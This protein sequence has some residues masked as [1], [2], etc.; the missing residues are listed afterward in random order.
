MISGAPGSGKTTQATALAKQYGLTNVN[1]NVLVKDETR[2]NPAIKRRIEVC[3][4]AGDP[5]PNEI[6]LRI[7][8]DRLK[9]SDCRMNGGVLD[10]FP[11]DEAQINLLK[12]MRVKP[13][14]FFLLDLEP[15][16]SKIRLS[17]RRIDPISGK[18]YALTEAEHRCHN[19]TIA[20]RLEI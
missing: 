2:R 16:D 10:G 17:E 9:C 4:D 7:V 20:N 13:D 5:I 11:E 12:S 18:M 3:R 6:L 15:A 8:E 19:E 1:V 14:V